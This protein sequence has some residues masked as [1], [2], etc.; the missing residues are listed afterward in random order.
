[1]KEL[2]NILWHQLGSK[3]EY[4]AEEENKPLAEFIR[5]LIGLDQDAVNRKFG[6]FLNGNNLNALQQEF[7]KAIIEYVK[8]NGNIA[9]EDL[10][11]E[12]FVDYNV[13]DLFGEKLPVVLEIINTVRNAV[14]AA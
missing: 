3:E 2:E 14:D 12:P 13:A 4:E 6:D 9:K 7:V 1:M 10:F 8:A 5:S 11:K